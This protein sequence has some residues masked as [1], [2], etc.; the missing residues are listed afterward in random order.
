M[1][2]KLAAQAMALDFFEYA[3][4]LLFDMNGIA[5][6]GQATNESFFMNPLLDP[7]VSAYFP[8]FNC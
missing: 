5:V 8:F 2:N 7:W 1:L 4:W 3:L 6:L